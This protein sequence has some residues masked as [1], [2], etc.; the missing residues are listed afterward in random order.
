MNESGSDDSIGGGGAKRA[1]SSIHTRVAGKIDDH[2]PSQRLNVRT[3]TPVAMSSLPS[4]QTHARNT[5]ISR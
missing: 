2:Q 4:A 5:T 3:G 1:R